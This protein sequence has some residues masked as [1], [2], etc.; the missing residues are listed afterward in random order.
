MPKE[1]LQFRVY[2][3]DESFDAQVEATYHVD[4]L[5]GADADGNRGSPR[6]FVDD[7]KIIKITN[8]QNQEIK[9]IPEGLRDTIAAGVDERI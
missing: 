4:G 2:W 7:V 3:D 5:Y 6:L 8:D 9:D 1:I